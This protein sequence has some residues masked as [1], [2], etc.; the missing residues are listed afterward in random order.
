MV[1][2]A[3]D[4]RRDFD[5]TLPTDLVC[6]GPAFFLAIRFTCPIITFRQDLELY[7]VRWRL[8]GR[9]F[10]YCVLP[11]LLP[12]SAREDKPRRDLSQR[13]DNFS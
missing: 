13:P 3:R 6:A 5:A 2:S 1:G 4:I 8:C 9:D 10:G 12:D 7:T 11:P